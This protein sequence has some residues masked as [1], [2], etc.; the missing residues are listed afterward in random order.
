MKRGTD[1]RLRINEP[2]I[3]FRI[4]NTVILTVLLLTM[5]VP[6][7]NTLVISFTSNMES[8][9]VAMK[10]WPREPSLQGYVTL[11]TQVQLWRPF[12]NN[13]VVTAVGVLFYVVCN[14]LAGFVLAREKFAGKGLVALLFLLPMMIPSEA[15]I[16]PRY[17]TMQRLGLIDTLWA[18]ILSGVGDTFAIYL[19][20]N[21]FL[22]IPRS[23]EESAHMDGASVYTVFR[24]IYFPL[25]TAGLATITLMEM[26]GKWNHFFSAVLYLHSETKQ[27]LQRAIQSI[28][29]PTESQLQTGQMISNNVR[30]AAIIVALVPML[31]LYPLI[32]K[33]FIKGI[34]LG[35]VKE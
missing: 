28:I 31:A 32:Q 12:L 30:T 3:A 7:W 18:V 29:A 17:I 22:S 14:S 16:I 15:I 2:P 19:M 6:M 21:Y 4:F 35:A 1:H 10:F 33:Y 11:L 24:K 20:R 8:Y 23:L 26:V 5:A 27:T 9:E 34:Y 13:V 25:S